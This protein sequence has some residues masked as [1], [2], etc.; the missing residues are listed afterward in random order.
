[1]STHILFPAVHLPCLVVRSGLVG[2]DEA[3]GLQLLDLSVDECP[4]RLVPLDVGVRKT[5]PV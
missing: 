3:F 2:K 5:Y 4:F 1:M